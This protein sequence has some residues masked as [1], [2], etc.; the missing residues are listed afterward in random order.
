MNSINLRNILVLLMVLSLNTNV[1]AAFI[2]SDS[3]SGSSLL[4]VSDAL[5]DLSKTNYTN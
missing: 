2:R 1:M 4:A 5:V 3:E